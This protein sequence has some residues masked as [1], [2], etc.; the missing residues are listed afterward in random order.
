MQAV[1][2]TVAFIIVVVAVLVTS[3]ADVGVYSMTK[4]IDSRIP[5]ATLGPKVYEQHNDFN[6]WMFSH[7]IFY[8]I[9]AFLFPDYI[10]LFFAISVIWELFEVAWNAYNRTDILWNTAG[11]ILGFS[12]AKAIA[13]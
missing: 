12:L 6:W 7:F 9:L 13:A 10:L 8:F 2:I 1:Q 3:F 11:I 5:S 4:K